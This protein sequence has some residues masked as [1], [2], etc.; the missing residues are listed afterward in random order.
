MVAC[1]VGCCAGI[2]GPTAIMAGATALFSYRKQVQEFLSKNY[3]KILIFALP[4]F[5][6][7]GMVLMGYVETPELKI[8]DF[9]NFSI[10]N[11][12]SYVPD[13]LNLQ[14]PEVQK[15]VEE[16]A[17]ATGGCPYAAAKA[18]AA[19]AGEPAPSGGCGC[20]K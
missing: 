2:C 16:V 14:Q 9:E 7:V 1:A 15:V 19:A 10:E 13:F 11:L 8:P 5:V 6:A 20:G 18:A 4:I 3:F 17:P 12:K